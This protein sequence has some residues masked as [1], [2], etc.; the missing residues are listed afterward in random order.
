MAQETDRTVELERGGMTGL[1]WT[2]LFVFVVVCLIGAQGFL[3]FSLRQSTMNE[4]VRNVEQALT[5][6]VESVL[7]VNAQNGTLPEFLDRLAPG[8]RLELPGVYG[9]FSLSR[10]SLNDSGYRIDDDH[11]V[12]D[13]RI[14]ES[15]HN[16]EEAHDGLFLIQKLLA[17]QGE[18]EASK[19]EQPNGAAEVSQSHVAAADDHGHAHDHGHGDEHSALI[20]DQSLAQLIGNLRAS[21][22]D[23][24][25]IYHWEK[26]QANSFDLSIAIVLPLDGAPVLIA[27]GWVPYDALLTSDR[28]RILFAFFA[29]ILLSVLG[30]WLALHLREKRNRKAMEAL[31]LTENVNRRTLEEAVRNNARMTTR[32]TAIL[33]GTS[34]AII[35]CKAD[36]TID[37]VNIA[38]TEL[39]GAERNALEGAGIE[40]FFEGEGIGDFNL[41]G[42]RGQSSDGVVQ[43]QV[44]RSD[45]QIVDVEVLV[46]EFFL[47]KER[48]IALNLRDISERLSAE[49]LAST[50]QQQ[51]SDAI[52]YL[53]DAF[54]LYDK[55]DKLL[56]CNE[57]YKE[58]YKTSEDLLVQG[59]SFEYI[60]RQGALRGQYNTNGMSISDWIEKRLSYHQREMS[61]MDQ[62]LDDGSWVRVHERKTPDGQTIGYRRDITE[63]KKRDHATLRLL[64]LMSE[65]L[66]DMGLAYL[67]VDASG[68]VMDF[69]GNAEKALELDGAIQK[70]EAASVYLPL[71][72]TLDDLPPVSI[73]GSG[74]DEA[75]K[76]ILW[77][78]KGRSE[79]ALVDFNG[80]ASGT[81][82]LLIKSVA[83]KA[84]QLDPI[85]LD[86][87]LEAGLKGILKRRVHPTL[88]GLSELLAEV[89]QVGFEGH[90]DS[91]VIRN[92]LVAAAESLKALK[93]CSD[94][95]G[96]ETED[97]EFDIRSWLRD[98]IENSPSVAGLS[99]SLAV[100][101]SPVVPK[102]VLADQFLLKKIMDAA[103]EATGQCA[104]ETAP[105]MQV[106]AAPVDGDAFDLRFSLQFT[107]AGRMARPFGGRVSARASTSTL[108]EL[109]KTAGLPAGQTNLPDGRSVVWFTFKVRIAAQSRVA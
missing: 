95:D 97:S 5:A 29:I 108:L 10:R 9:P 61:T 13:K 88:V 81:M 30:L 64:T 103:L 22:F 104:S 17:E 86:D 40:T 89:E 79:F 74:G 8:S 24:L 34:D 48:Y 83:T 109:A 35:T 107:G 58:L 31:R 20:T 27:D 82:I 102:L 47:E 90:A 51:L 36:G 59:T 7:K 69:S 105:R 21:N 75:D 44:I 38:A 71:T 63:S 2:L 15:F 43:A 72:M 4:R 16:H 62:R 87:D 46:S 49:G 23:H 37:G 18:E 12:I 100:E 70:G 77:S 73:S 55:D 14:Y 25:R 3:F 39:L 84:S 26:E 65:L 106:E 1:R 11:L 45:G 76:Q 50:A 53:P 28:Q 99:S 19:H 41:L 66:V 56:V 101:V 68:K 98:C 67:L 94:G 96:C 57:R 42:T 52:N 54:V 6:Q 60:I 32:L 80:V 33:N 92:A 85:D 91:K 78:A 93:R